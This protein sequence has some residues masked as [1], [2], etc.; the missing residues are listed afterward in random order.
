ML[1]DELLFFGVLANLVPRAYQAPSAYNSGPWVGGKSSSDG[2]LEVWMNRK[3]DRWTDHSAIQLFMSWWHG[4]FRSWFA[5]LMWRKPFDCYVRRAE[6][7]E[8]RA[9]FPLPME[10]GTKARFRRDIQA[11]GWRSQRTGVWSSSMA[12]QGQPI[13]WSIE[14][15]CQPIA[16][17]Q[18]T[19]QK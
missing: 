4:L 17:S 11:V 1:Y 16:G 19:Q 18:V 13:N 6:V 9:Q 8:S 15:L 10:H 14:W 7:P 3:M 2:R 12:I 5:E